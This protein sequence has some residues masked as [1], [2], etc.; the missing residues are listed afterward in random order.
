MTLEPVPVL[1]CAQTSFA[2]WTRVGQPSSHPDAR[3][4]HNL[5]RSERPLADLL[6]PHRVIQPLQFQQIL[7]TAGLYDTSSLEHINP[8]RVKDGRESMRDKNRNQIL[9]HR[10]VP[11]SHRDFLFSQRVQ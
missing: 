1:V 6:A 9:P 2:I 8:I 5:R 11:D 7:M 3:S 4:R 10:N